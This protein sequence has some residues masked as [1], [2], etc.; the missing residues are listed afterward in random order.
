MLNN[1]Q[2]REWNIMKKVIAVL[3]TLGLTLTA[4]PTFAADPVAPAHL[5]MHPQSK[6]FEY[7]GMDC[8]KYWRI[9]KC[10]PK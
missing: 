2:T 8:W 5:N 7:K 4:T 1:T 3:I 6:Y 10:L 9:T